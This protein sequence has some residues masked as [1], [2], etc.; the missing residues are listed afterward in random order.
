VKK[1]TGRATEENPAALQPVVEQLTQYFAGQRQQFD[2]PLDWSVM[3]AFQQKAMKLVYDIPFGQTRTYQQIAQALD[4]PLAI[5][6][7]GRANAT[8]PMPIVVPCHRVIGSN[9]KLHG[10]GG[11]LEAKAYLLNLEGSWLL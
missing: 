6:A 10:Y 3:S 2:L 11:G 5:R 1:L 8:N 9:G 4:N 7:V